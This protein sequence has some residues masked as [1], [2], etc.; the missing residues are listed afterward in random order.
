MTSILPPNSTDLEL[1]LEAATARIGAVPV[2]NATLWDAANCP[3]AFLPWLAFALSVDDWNPDWPEATKRAVIAASVSVHRRKGTVGAMRRAMIAADYGS[4]EI[5]EAGSTTVF[6][7]DFLFDGSLTYTPT[8]HW[9]EYRIILAAPITLLAAAVLRSFLASVAPVRCRLKALDFT[10]AP[11]F[12]NGATSFDG[13]YT[14]G[15]A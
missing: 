7:G 8:D 10:G 14:H 12:Y 4:A 11:N 2:P 3:A 13:A 9:A 5:R 1:A 15:V 6:N